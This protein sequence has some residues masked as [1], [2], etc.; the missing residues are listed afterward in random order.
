MYDFN[1]YDRETD[2]DA[3]INEYEQ[4]LVNNN[5]YG[6][7]KSNHK[8]KNKKLLKKKSYISP[9]LEKIAYLDPLSTIFVKS[10][11]KKRGR[12]SHSQSRKRYN[13]I[14]EINE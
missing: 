10:K 4:I 12:V 1:L 14:N 5:I 9:N 8:N 11:T 2:I 3:L 6:K 13:V 7:N